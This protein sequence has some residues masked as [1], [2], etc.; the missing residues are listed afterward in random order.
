MNP[1]NIKPIVNAVQH[2][3][4]IADA[5]FAGNYS[6]CIYLLKMREYYR[7]ETGKSYTASLE[8]DEVGRWLSAREALWDQLAEADYTPLPIAGQQLDP[9]DSEQINRLLNPHGYVYSSGL[10]YQHR[11]HF[12]IGRLV[13]HETCEDYRL[14]VAAQ[15]YARDLT[16]PP[17]YSLD[18]TIFI[19]QESLKRIIWEKIEEWKWRRH[20][21][22]LS[23]AMHYYDY[24]QN[25]EQALE[26]IT[27]RET[28][29]V[30]LHEIGELKADTLLGGQ[31]HEMLASLPRSQAEFMVRAVRDHLADCLSTLPALLQGQ[32]EGAI[33]FYFGNYTSVRKKLFPK[34]SAAYNN[35][36]SS[37]AQHS[38]LDAAQE[39]YEHW[40]AVAAGILDIYR[41]HRHD[42]IDLIERYIEANTL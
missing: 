20:N 28:E 1:L 31:W 36:V 29:T 16:A 35:W 40:K 22:A 19:R 7:W 15:E 12:F 37:Q 18:N 42:S 34:L 21:Q 39:G 3:C 30:L 10:G 27:R 33:H 13:R 38:L 17:G 41:Q 11:P 25:I 4:H 2:N 24:E 32:D 26:Q 8:N 23:R 6:L 9:W 5:R 14:Y